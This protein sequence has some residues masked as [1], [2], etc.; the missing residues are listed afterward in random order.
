MRRVLALAVLALSLAG[1]TTVPTPSNDPSKLVGLWRVGGVLGESPDTWLL[2]SDELILWS[3]CGVL[4]GSWDARG[5]AFVAGIDGGIGEACMSAYVF[6]TAPWLT[7]AQGFAQTET[8]MALLD[9]NGET[10]ATLTIDGAPPTSENYIDEY[11]EQ[12]TVNVTFDSAIN[13]PEGVDVATD[14]VGRWIDPAHPDDGTYIEYRGD[15]KWSGSDGCNVFGGSYALGADGALLTTTGPI[16]LMGCDGSA[17]A[18]LPSS[19]AL[20]GK[21]ETGLTFYDAD[22]TAAIEVV[23]G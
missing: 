2:L 21:T 10:L 5:D 1:C 3:Q 17:I 16:T 8:G 4:T 12:P 20:V 23:P 14:V 6:D 18:Y 7:N 13:V 19:A 15:G 9:A 11:T 22:G